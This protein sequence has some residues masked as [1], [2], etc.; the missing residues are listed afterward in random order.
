MAEA[1][2]VG[3]ECHVQVGR[4][5]RRHLVAEVV[6]H[7]HHHL[8]DRR[9]V[10]VDHIDVAEAGVGRVM[11]D[12][13]DGRVRRDVLHAAAGSLQVARVEEEDQLRLHAAGRTFVNVAE[14]R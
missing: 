13:D 4:D 2:G 9:R 8:T 11:V 5:R 3:E 1:A 6:E 14:S 7:V 12:V 10:G